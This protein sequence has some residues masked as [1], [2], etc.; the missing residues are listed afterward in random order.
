ML[1]QYA[2]NEANF[3]C[4]FLKGVANCWLEIYFMFYKGYSGA[5]HLYLS[6]NHQK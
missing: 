3:L 2:Q 5:I 6:I 1:G 4:T